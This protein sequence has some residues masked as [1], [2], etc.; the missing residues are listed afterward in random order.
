MPVIMP[1]RAVIV[2]DE[3]VQAAMAAGADIERVCLGRCARKSGYPEN[4]TNGRCLYE[5]QHDLSLLGWAIG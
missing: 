1:A 2:A 5:L 3:D 4:C